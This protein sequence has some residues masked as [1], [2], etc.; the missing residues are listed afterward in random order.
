MDAATVPSMFPRVAQSRAAIALSRQASELNT[1]PESRGASFTWLR[2]HTHKASSPLQW[3]LRPMLGCLHPL[4]HARNKRCRDT[5]HHRTD[6]SW[7]KVMSKASFAQCNY[8]HITT[9]A[10]KCAHF[11]LLSLQSERPHPREATP[12]VPPSEWNNRHACACCPNA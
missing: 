2:A 3:T 12:Q 11:V 4:W 8:K 5:T 10:T 9:I 7:T 6:P 1:K